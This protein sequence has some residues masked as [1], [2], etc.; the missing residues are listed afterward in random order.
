VRV[1]LLS[2]LEPAGDAGTPRGL[3]RVGGRTIVEHQLAA[4]IAFGCERIV[5]LAEG[6]PREL[7]KIQ[8]LAESSGIGF[9]VVANGH[10]LAA[11]VA[12][13][14]ELLVISGG[15]LAP[16]SELMALV[17][18]GN[19]IVVQPAEDGVAAGF[20]RLDLHRANA[21]VMR[22]PSSLALRLA[23]LPSEWNPISALL[24]I[25][26]QTGVALHPLP[27]RLS[28]QG[29]WML[30]RSETEA[31]AIEPRWLRLHTSGAAARGLGA[32][33]AASLIQRFGPA[34]LHAGTRPRWATLAAL[35][36][37]VA[38]LALSWSGVAIAAFAF[39]GLAWIAQQCAELLARIVRDS[40]PVLRRRWAVAPMVS[41]ALDAAFV[42]CCVAR[43]EQTDELALQRLP[44]AFVALA[45]FGHLRLLPR[46][47][48]ARR[49][50]PWIEDRFVV[51]L[52]LACASATAVFAPALMAG[53]LM[54]ICWAMAAASSPLQ[55]QA[56]LVPAEPPG[57]EPR[58]VRT[59]APSP[60][61]VPRMRRAPAE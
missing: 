24:R 61:S 48:P 26:A 23:H 55:V 19:G 47:F 31:Q 39:L 30:V 15:L 57:S 11:S 18:A 1:A 5:C 44:A 42:V 43:L 50:A 34:L 9:A 51:A 36:L 54:M 56:P 49:W 3:L 4:A 46:L 52:L 33:V 14:D 35:L 22:L 38:G 45:V 25:A 29:F 41:W 12:L 2:T 40:M 7:R 28:R 6:F 27:D 60:R 20:E 13:H 8:R 32:W 17:E 21:G 59:D 58:P 16:A 37:G 10:E 53:A